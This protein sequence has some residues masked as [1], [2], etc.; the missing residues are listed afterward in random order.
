MPVVLLFTLRRLLTARASVNRD[1]LG[2]LVAVGA[3][4]VLASGGGGGGI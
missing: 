4:S 2:G 1:K 3:G